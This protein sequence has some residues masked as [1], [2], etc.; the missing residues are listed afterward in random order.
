MGGYYRAPL[1][2][3]LFARIACTPDP[4]LGCQ[5]CVDLR[6]PWIKVP[7]PLSYS[8]KASDQLADSYT[9][10]HTSEVKTLPTELPI[11]HFCINK[12]LGYTSLGNLEVFKCNNL[13]GGR[14]SNMSYGDFYPLYPGSRSVM[15][16]SQRWAVR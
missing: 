15:N 13:R 16:F 7:V 12:S 3:L 14:S 10:S 4:F 11:P 5:D 8:L 6:I 2:L 9:R 1:T